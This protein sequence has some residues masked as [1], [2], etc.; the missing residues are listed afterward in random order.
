MLEEF[1]G[2]GFEAIVVSVKAD[3]LGPEWLGRKIDESFI[4]DLSKLSEETGFDLCGELGEYHT[5]VL[6]GPIF[7]KRIGIRS[8]QKTFREDMKRWLLEVA[9]FYLKEKPKARPHRP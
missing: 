2:L 4:S 5:L 9:D 1:V 3:L 8:C 6:D 7:N